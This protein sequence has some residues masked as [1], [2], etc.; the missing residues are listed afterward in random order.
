MED[1][2]SAGSAIP[3]TV[4]KRLWIRRGREQFEF[5]ERALF[6]VFDINIPFEHE[7]GPPRWVDRKTGEMSI[8]FM[9]SDGGG[10]YQARFRIRRDGKYGTKTMFGAY[11]SVEKEKTYKL[12]KHK[13]RI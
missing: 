8:M 6:G 3:C 12:W 1:N 11:G 4:L 10:T 9:G 2:F 13:V 7:G 5:P